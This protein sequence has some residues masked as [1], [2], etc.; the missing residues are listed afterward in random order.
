V[1]GRRDLVAIQTREKGGRKWKK[2]NRN[3]YKHDK[4]NWKSIYPLKVLVM[5][6]DC[7]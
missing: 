4:I 3:K 6:E 5:K 7:G 1:I 2:L